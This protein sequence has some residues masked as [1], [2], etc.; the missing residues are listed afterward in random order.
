MIEVVAVAWFDRVADVA[1]RGQSR[2]P[3]GDSPEG[4][5][6][7]IS[8]RTRVGSLLVMLWLLVGVWVAFT[9]SYITIAWLKTLVSA[10]LA[11][12]LWPLLLLGVDLH[13]R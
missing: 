6:S 8:S 1:L 5:P 12:I 2:T 13:L 4:G 3:S 9:H 7:M 10:L 11:V